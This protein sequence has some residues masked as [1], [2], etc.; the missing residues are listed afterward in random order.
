MG[1][2]L[3]P[4]HCRR[5]PHR[6]GLGA[7][8]RPPAAPASQAQVRGRLHSRLR[9]R[10]AISLHYDLSN[11]FY[12]LILEP[13]MAYSCGY[14]SSPDVSLEQAQRAKLDLVC[15]K[16]GLEPGMTLLDVGCGWGSLSLHAAEHFGAQVTGVT[17]AAEQ[18]RFIDARIPERGLQ[19]RVKIRLRDYR[20]VDR[21]ST[22]RSSRSRWA[23]TSARTTTRPTS[24]CC[25]AR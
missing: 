3:S 2:R 10:S 14:H 4:A 1:G 9:D 15:R 11:E 13:Q 12:A 8:G 22:T 16:L 24:R 21:T 25:T 20:D 6:G 18:K 7:L 23:S 5:R 17:I 19:D